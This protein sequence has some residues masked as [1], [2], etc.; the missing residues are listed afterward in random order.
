VKCSFIS[1][2]HLDSAIPE[3]VE[4]FNRFLRHEVSRC[5]ELY[6]LGDL[7]EVWIGDDDDSP[8]AEALATELLDAAKRC[9]IRLMHGNRDFLIG[10]AFARS[11]GVEL[12]DDPFM[13]E[14]NGQRL[15]L[16]HGDALCVDDVAY[17]HT[18]EMLR[19][20]AWQD[21]VKAKPLAERRSMAAAMRTKSRNANANKPSN[22]MDVADRAVA[23]AVS[24]HR[25]TALIHGHTHRPGIHTIG[26]VAK[27]YVLGDWNRCGWVLRFD[28][29]F[30]LSRFP[31]AGHYEI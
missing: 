3:R 15:L 22:I 9:R 31:L 14:R 17:Q 5:D 26:T 16:C 1:D 2:L 6:L 25:A 27:R 23:A 12:I 21:E 28:G 30:T 20:N 19:S 18:R 29:K 24:L 13:I 4:A 8:F 10:G 7:T 11:T